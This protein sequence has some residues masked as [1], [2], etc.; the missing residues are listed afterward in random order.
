[1]L[2][3]TIHVDAESAAVAYGSGIVARMAYVL[4]LVVGLVA[5][6]ISGII[7]TGASIILVPVL[8]DDR[9][10]D[11]EAHCAQAEPGVLSVVAGRAPAVL[12][13]HVAL[14]GES[15]SGAGAPSK[16]GAPDLDAKTFA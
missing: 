1:M 8:A 5:G 3:R 11:R 10:P 7:G 6:T 9:R 16:T 12:G 2:W 4:V 13:P 14:G 15:L